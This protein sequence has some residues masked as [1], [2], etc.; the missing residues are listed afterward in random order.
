MTD[1]QKTAALEIMDLFKQAIWEVDQKQL[2]DLELNHQISSLGIDS[3]AMLEVIGFLE[4]E[5]EIHLPDEMLANVKTVGDLA[6]AVSKV[7]AAA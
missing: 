1:A 7:R 6:M 4:D 3:V 2:D 5:L